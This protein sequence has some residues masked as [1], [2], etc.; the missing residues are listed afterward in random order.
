MGKKKNLEDKIWNLVEEE[1]VRIKEFLTK[2]YHDG[3]RVDFDSIK[4]V[5]KLVTDSPASRLFSEDADGKLKC[6][7]IF[8]D[9][10]DKD[11]KS[12]EINFFLELTMY[13]NVL[14]DPH[15]VCGMF[16]TT[17]EEAP[18]YFCSETENEQN[19]LSLLFDCDK[20]EAYLALEEFENTYDD[21]QK[22]SNN[23]S[24][25]IRL[26]E[27]HAVIW[28]TNYDEYDSKNY[29]SKRDLGF[30]VSFSE[31]DGTSIIE[32][33][34]PFN[35]CILDQLIPIVEASKDTVIP[36]GSQPEAVN[37]T[38]NQCSQRP[39][40]SSGKDKRTK[41]LEGISKKKNVSLPPI[42]TPDNMASPEDVVNE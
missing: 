1:G 36:A 18:I 33:I 12:M 3:M 23:K 27:F 6:L 17:P 16:K 8:N 28:G 5:S 38:K 35:V 13:Q 21:D 30:M 39:T 22:F 32:R 14:C 40:P 41:I 19:V 24:S 25:F 29:E 26:S 15:I 2:F 20:K 4:Q 31:A 10:G 7:R 34:Y 11:M 9:A 37:S 42:N